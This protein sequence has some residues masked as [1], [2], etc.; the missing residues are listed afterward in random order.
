MCDIPWWV[1]PAGVFIGFVALGAL[2]AAKRMD[3]STALILI[4]PIIIWPVSLAIALPIL[5]GVA[6][7]RIVTR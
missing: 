7:V 6:G 2:A 4:I 3:E 1:Y 5:V